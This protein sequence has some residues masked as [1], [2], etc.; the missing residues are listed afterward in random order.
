MPCGTNQNLS[1]FRRPRLRKAIRTISSSPR[2]PQ[3]IG[4]N[5]PLSAALLRNTFFILKPPFLPVLLAVYACIFTN[6]LADL[7][8]IIRISL[9]HL[10]KHL[11]SIHGRP[12]IS[13]SDG[14]NQNRH[15]LFAMGHN[16]FLAWFLFII[17]L[18]TQILKNRLYLRFDGCVN[19]ILDFRLG[20]L[21]WFLCLWRLFPHLRSR[22]FRGG[23]IFFFGFLGGFFRFF[24]LGFLF[25][26]GFFRHLFKHGLLLS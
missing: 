20:C 9:G 16:L 11:I 12:I 14:F 1:G 13:A 2:K 17:S 25:L 23:L 21:G 6:H 19:L 7:L 8:G 26:L 15:G 22:F 18:I 3:T 24:S 5:E 4:W 10:Q